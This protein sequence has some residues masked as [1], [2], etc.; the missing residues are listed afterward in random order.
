MTK[1]LLIYFWPLWVFVA[2]RRLSLVAMHRLF[3]VVAP[4]VEHR[5]QQLQRVGSALGARR[6]SCSAACGSF[7]DQGSSPC[8]C[9][10]RQILIH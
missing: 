1:D 7:L 8:P 4:L 9:A 2:A 10:G 3:V 5:L 6:L